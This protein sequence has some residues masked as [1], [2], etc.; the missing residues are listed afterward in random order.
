[1]SPPWVEDVLT[2]WFQD[3]GPRAWFRGDPQLDERIRTRFYEVYA[4]LLDVPEAAFA[5]AR[6]SLAAVSV[7][8]PFPRNMFRGEARAFATDARALSISLRAMSAGVDVQLDADER[9]VLYMPLQH[10]ED[11]LV[12]A[13]S[14]E[15]FTA[16]GNANVLGYAHAHKE[17][18][19]RF[20][21]FPHRNDA[22]ARASTPEEIEFIRTHTGF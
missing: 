16:L 20:G 8:D 17:I 4:G 12:Q 9:V 6:E 7:F 19:D 15:V 3:V 22:L 13:R 10:S 1:V 18:I 5:A 2:F 11:A 21:R 14:I